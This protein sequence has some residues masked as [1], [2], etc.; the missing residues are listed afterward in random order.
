[1]KKI[2]IHIHGSKIQVA[3]VKNIFKTDE[4]LQ[5]TSF[6]K[7]DIVYSIYGPGIE[8]KHNLIYWL[9]T[10]KI[11]LIHWIGNDAEI[12]E[13]Q[14]GNFF[15]KIVNFAKLQI[16]YFK[17]RQS[18]VIFIASSPWLAKSI[19]KRTG[20]KTKYIVLTSIYSEEMSCFLRLQ[21]R[22]ID[23]L[24]YSP[25][26]TGNLHSIIEVLDVAK[27]FPDKSFFIL[28]PDLS[29][30]NPFP[31]ITT[32]NVTIMPKQDQHQ[33]WKLYNDTNCFLRLK[34]SGDAI[35]L[36]VLE[37]LFYKCDVIWNY[38]FDNCIKTEI[39]DLEQVI[40]N[41]IKNKKLN[42]SGHN[43]IIQHYSIDKWRKEF[44]NYLFKIVE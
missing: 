15:R 11:H 9:F 10:K 23:F 16:L 3:L 41:Q 34:K 31:F 24:I 12:F 43:M 21:E 26:S 17:L 30:T 14:K 27:K 29:N 36:S 33:M 20:I 39:I 1:M 8:F 7:C 32:S 19:E 6:P 35:S 2:K 25:I 13:S 38:E 42:E 5:L 40:S 44:V 28:C 18:K 4:N 22:K 37:A